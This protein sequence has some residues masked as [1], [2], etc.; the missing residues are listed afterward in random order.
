MLGNVRCRCCCRACRF[1]CLML[2]LIWRALA[3]FGA[4]SVSHPSTLFDVAQLA[5]SCPS[6]RHPGNHRTNHRRQVNHRTVV[7]QSRQVCDRL[8][9]ASAG[10]TGRLEHSRRINIVVSCVWRMVVGRARFLISDT[11]VAKRHPRSLRFGVYPVPSVVFSIP[12]IFS[13]IR[14]HPVGAWAVWLA[15]VREHGSKQF[16]SVSSIVPLGNCHKEVPGYW[17]RRSLSQRC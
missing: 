10:L 12:L 4:A 9:R 1:E 3:A 17:S 13:S 2:C 8:G 11:P 16:R 14:I 5:S 6:A 15:C 7:C